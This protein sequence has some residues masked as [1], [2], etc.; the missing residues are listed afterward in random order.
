MCRLKWPVYLLLEKLVWIL[1]NRYDVRLPG[2]DHEVISSTLQGEHVL[3]SLDYL[4]WR[5]ALL[6]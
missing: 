6:S 2:A 4:E 3:L 5:P 1:A